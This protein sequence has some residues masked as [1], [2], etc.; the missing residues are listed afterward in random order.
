MLVLQFGSAVARKLSV[1]ATEAV[2]ID[3]ADRTDGPLLR[4][5]HSRWRHCGMT[6]NLKWYLS[7]ASSNKKGNGET[8]E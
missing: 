6:F 2:L 4:I 7:L 3:L 1:G 8:Y 5:F